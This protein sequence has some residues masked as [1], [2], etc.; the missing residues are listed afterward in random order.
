MVPPRASDPGWAHGIMVNGGRQKIKCKYCNKVMLGGG[1][2]RLKQHLAGERGNVAPC[3][4]VP[5]EVKVQI[6]QLLGFKVLE[7]LKRQ[8][9]GSKNAVSC[10]P[11]REEI[12]DGT[13]GVQNS[14]RH[15]LRRKAK[16]VREGVTKEAKRKKK[17]LLP[18]TFVTQ[19]V[20]Q[21]TAQIE[22]IEQA[23]MAVAKFVYQAGIPITVVNSQYFQQMADAIAAVGPGY[24]MPTYYSLMGKLLDRSVQ[25]VGEYVE[26]LRKSWEVTGCSVLVDRWVDRTGSVVI[27]FFVYCSKGTM[28]LKSVDS[29]EISESAEGLLNLFDT[30]VQEVGPKNIVNFVTDSSSLFKAAGILLVEKYKTFFSSVCAAHCVELILEE[31]EKTVEVKEI[32]G[33]A[34]R[35]VQFIYNNVWVL[36]QIK[37]RSGGREIIH[38]ASTRYFSIFLTLQNILSLKDHLHQTFTS[39]AWMQSDLS[40]YGAGLEVT[41]ITA[42]PQFWSKCDHIT[43]G[44]KPLLSVLQFLESE[45][46]PSAGFI[47]DAFEKMKSSVMLAF[48]QKESVYLP[49]LKAI[50]HVLLKEFQSSLHVAACYLNPSIFYSPTFLSSKVIQKGLLDCIEALEPDITSQVMITNNINFYEEAVGDFGRPVALHGRDSLAPATW[51]SLYGTDYP[52]LQRLAVRIL[53]QTCSVVQC[54]KRCSMFNYL[55]LKK[56]W[57]EKQKMNDLAFAHYNLQLQERRPETCKARCSIDAVDPV[58]LEAIDANMEDWVDVK[59]TNQETLVTT[60]ET[61]VEHKLSNRDSCIGSTDERST[62]ETR[63]TDD[64]TTSWRELSLC[65]AALNSSKVTFPSL[66]ESIR[67][68]ISSNFPG[69]VMSTG[70]QSSGA[71]NGIK[72]KEG[73]I[74]LR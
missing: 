16:E 68:N 36:N 4:E 28:F 72:I 2:S 34:K 67:S 7:K 50:D 24:K 9:N 57:L 23:D 59:V 30:I 15:S 12:N 66:L 54:R 21:N 52:D 44:T 69:S 55:Y 71:K 25:D 65:M 31:I 33:K 18:T 14:R 45:E 58:L 1:I 41:K 49:Y 27:N 22:S 39:D 6:Q 51:W 62:E 37:K 73:A 53:S 3:E 61:L 29:S 56:N 42:D 64:R 26:E 63:D 38:L 32:V 35:I 10:F 8:K 47:F 5:E 17:H 40:Q 48:N 46:K 70:R 43:M 19:S 11:S 74:L 13:H 60:Q 20:N